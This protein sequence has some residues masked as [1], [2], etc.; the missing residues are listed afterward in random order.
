MILAGRKVN[1]KDFV[2]GHKRNYQVYVNKVTPS[3]C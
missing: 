1:P 2:T 3:D